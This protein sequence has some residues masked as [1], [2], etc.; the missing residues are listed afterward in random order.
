[1]QQREGKHC[2]NGRP[3]FRPIHFRPTSIRPK[4]CIKSIS[5]NPNLIGLDENAMDENALDENWAHGQKEC[6]LTSI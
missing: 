1:M 4:I 2:Q 3:T 6:S 5:S